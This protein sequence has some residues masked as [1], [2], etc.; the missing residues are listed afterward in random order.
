MRLKGTPELRVLERLTPL[1]L[2][3]AMRG[4]STVRDMGRDWVLPPASL[5]GAIPHRTGVEESRRPTRRALAAG[6]IPA[7]VGLPIGPLPKRQQAPPSRQPTNGRDGVSPSPPF[8]D[9]QLYLAEALKTPR[10]GG[11]PQLVNFLPC[12]TLGAGFGGGAK[13]QNPVHAS[14][15][16]PVNSKPS[17]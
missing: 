3:T 15:V 11:P 6:G 10:L 17:V 16:G 9:Q 2:L 12:G 5:A 14:A 4:P 7:V 13:C 8:L 1:V